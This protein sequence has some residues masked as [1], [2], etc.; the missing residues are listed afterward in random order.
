MFSSKW[1]MHLIRQS[2]LYIYVYGLSGHSITLS[3]FLTSGF[4]A[5]RREEG[6]CKLLDLQLAR[7]LLIWWKHSLQLILIGLFSR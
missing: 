6:P 1:G 7:P 4:V 3:D 2:R 5:G